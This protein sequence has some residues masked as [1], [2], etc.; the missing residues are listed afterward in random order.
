MS[1]TKQNLTAQTT[2]GFRV[3]A[4]DAASP[5]NV[6]AYSGTQ[7]ATTL[8]APTVREQVY[9]LNN[10]CADSG[11]PGGATCTPTGTTF[12]ATA[13]TFDAATDAITVPL[14]GFVGPANTTIVAAFRADTAFL[15]GAARYIYGDTTTPAYANR[16]QI[17][18]EGDRLTIGLG[19]THALNPDVL[20]AALALNTWY[21]VVLRIRPDGT[22]GVTVLRDGNGIIKTAAG[23]YTGLTSLAATGAI[24]NNGYNNVGNGWR[25]SIGEVRLINRLWSDAEIDAYCSANVPGCPG[26]PP[27]PTFDPFVMTSGSQGDAVTAASNTA[28][29]VTMAGVVGPD[30]AACLTL[31]HFILTYGTQVQP[32]ATCALNGTSLQASVT[33]PPPDRNT[34]IALTYAPTAQQIILTNQTVSTPDESAGFEQ[35]QWICRRPGA[36]PLIHW[37]GPINSLCTV[38]SPGAIDVQMDLVWAGQGESPA[39]TYALWCDATPD[40]SLDHA[41]RLGAAFHQHG[42]LPLRYAPQGAHAH[43]L[44]DGTPIVAVMQAAMGTIPVAGGTMRRQDASG[45]SPTLQPNEAIEYRFALEVEAGIAVGTV[46]GCELRPAQSNDPLSSVVPARIRVGSAQFVRP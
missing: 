3:A 41:V 43:L 6:S 33:V 1:Y 28:I 26:S 32:L 44:A 4:F 18:L 29:H 20:G 12:T 19:G 25:G 21:H 46:F 39:Q 36:S 13:A 23:T 37:Q 40:D 45:G 16:R 30:P 27:P 24:G 9:L 15:A 14:A 8:A 34:V 2:Y 10:S 22:Y 42:V 17:Y 11:T 7:Y 31:S 38:P 5:A 35:R